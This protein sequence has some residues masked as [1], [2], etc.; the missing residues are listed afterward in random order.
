MINFRSLFFC[1]V[2]VAP[3]ALPALADDPYMTI[4]GTGIDGHGLTTECGG[5]STTWCGNVGTAVDPDNTDP[6]A[7]LTYLLSQEFTVS[8]AGTVANPYVTA[9]T[10]GTSDS[11]ISSVTAGYLVVYGVGGSAGTGGTS[12]DGYTNVVAVVDFENITLSSLNV[13]DGS[14]PV[15]YSGTNGATPCK[16][17]INIVS[18]TYG[19]GPAAF[20]YQYPASGVTAGLPNAPTGTPTID[21]TTESSGGVVSWDPSNI[22]KYDNSVGFGSYNGNAPGYTIQLSTPEPDAVVLTAGM[23]GM[24]WLGMAGFRKRQQLI[25]RPE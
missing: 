20:I 6:N 2:A 10:P 9:Y 7:T 12:W 22:A 11:G 19:T 16:D 25:G 8:G 5:V 14:N 4:T 15:S 18:C 21:T 24:V 1:A 3:F 13:I 23:L 17:G